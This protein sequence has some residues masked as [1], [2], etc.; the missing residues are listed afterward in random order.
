MCAGLLSATLAMTIAE[1]LMTTPK[2]YADEFSVIRDL[3]FYLVVPIVIGMFISKKTFEL[4]E[5][6]K[7]TVFQFLRMSFRAFKQRFKQN[8][9]EK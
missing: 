6:R 5:K 3:T 7:Q 4:R 1:L 9:D 2:S 8:D